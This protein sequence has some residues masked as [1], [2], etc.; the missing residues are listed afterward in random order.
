L[1]REREA[2]LLAHYT[3]IHPASKPGV[4]IYHDG[5]TVT[6][7]KTFRQIPPILDADAGPDS[8]ITKL[9]MVREGEGEVLRDLGTKTIQ[10]KSA[11]GFVM[12]LKDAKPGSGFDALEVWVDPKTDL[13]V[14]FGF[15]RKD[16]GS[17][18]L[19]RITDCQWEIEIDPKLFDP[20]APPGYIDI[21]PPIQE[22]D[23]AGIVAA[24]KLYADLSGGRYPHEA[25]FD[26]EAVFDEMLELAGFMGPPRPE[27]T[28]DNRF[29]QI[30]QARHSLIWVER[31]LRDTTN[32]G[33]YGA[34]VRPADKD[35]IL[36]W[37]NVATSG[38]ENPYRV[39]YGDLQT[40][41]LPLARWAKLV[42]PE[43]AEG[44]LPEEE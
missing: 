10:G 5:R 13:P 2:G 32:T 43:V 7:V 37:W 29:T 33:Y 27:W 12:A 44:H 30:Q 31:L 18:S 9:R 22:K 20:T 11:R 38:A 28:G 40:E 17:T 36:L 8:P 1:P 41:I 6:M 39:F 16:G 26:A 23:I 24:L 4:L 3:G 25:T 21:S 15:E 35:K 34:T 42:P 19:Y 14:E